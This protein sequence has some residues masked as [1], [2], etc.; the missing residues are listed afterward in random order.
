[1]AL[2]SN[3]IADIVKN[4]QLSAGDTG[5]PEV[6]VA[7]LT[8]RIV[9]LTEHFKDHKKDFHSQRGL[10]SLVNQRRSLLRYLK[11]I[12]ITRYRGIIQKLGLRDSY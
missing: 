7:L 1:M 5:S 8:S 6:Q 9:Y 10:Q 2:A 3:D 4:N 11:R 12:S